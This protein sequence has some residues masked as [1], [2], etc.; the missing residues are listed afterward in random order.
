MANTKQAIKMVRKIEKRTKHNRWW[1]QQIKTTIKAV[2]ES[3]NSGN[4]QSMKKNLSLLNKKV[5]KAS[6]TGAIHKN[7]AGRIKSKYQLKV[8]K[9]ATK[10]TKKIEKE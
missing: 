1:K 4:K 6:K 10:K 2:V 9:L 5:D 3:I 8:N 7:K